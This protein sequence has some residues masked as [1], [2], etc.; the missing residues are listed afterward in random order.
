[1]ADEVASSQAPGKGPKAK[2]MR[3]TQTTTK[4]RRQPEQHDERWTRVVE[5]VARSLL[6]RDMRKASRKGG[7]Q[8]DRWAEFWRLLRVAYLAGREGQR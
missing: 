8:A 7:I 3:Q 6:V 1:L 5:Q 2:H 4:T